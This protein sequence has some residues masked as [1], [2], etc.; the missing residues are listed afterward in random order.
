MMTI[1]PLHFP[2]T[3][4]KQ[5]LILGS[6]DTTYPWN[7]LASS[8]SLFDDLINYHYFTFP[9]TS[10]KV[11]SASVLHLRFTLISFKL[12]DVGSYVPH[13]YLKIIMWKLTPL[14]YKLHTHSQTLETTVKAI[15]WP[16]HVLPIQNQWRLPGHSRQKIKQN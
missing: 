10:P 7:C 13:R 1:L 2:I 8:A 15:T 5:F 4:S 12:F 6:H 11:S 9:G 3:N 16:S 14:T